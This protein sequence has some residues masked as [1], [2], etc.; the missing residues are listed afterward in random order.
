MLLREV[1]GEN[2]KAERISQNK[3]LRDI[4]GLGFI[5]LGYLSELERGIKEASSEIL[6][7]VCKSLDITVSELLIRAAA[8]LE[9]YNN[10][11]VRQR[12][13]LTYAPP[14]ISM[15]WKN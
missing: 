5:S 13:Y 4:S 11:E 10:I 9:F 12:N 7:R 1:I 2:L 3:T 15:S 14:Q 6:E 8:D